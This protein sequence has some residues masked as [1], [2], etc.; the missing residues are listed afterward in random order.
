MAGRLVSSDP[1]CNQHT[2]LIMLDRLH[3]YLTEVREQQ[4]NAAGFLACRGI[5][6]NDLAAAR[7]DQ[8][9]DE[10]D[11]D[12][13]AVLLRVE[14]RNRDHLTTV[15]TGNVITERDSFTDFEPDPEVGLHLSVSSDFTCCRGR[16][17]V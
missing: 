3:M 6:H 11:H 9:R 14:L 1:S 17:V 12:D 15:C 4:V 16:L 2:T 8:F 10:P 13:A 5:L 7:D